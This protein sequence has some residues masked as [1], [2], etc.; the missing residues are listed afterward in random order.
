MTHV[1][2]VPE[3]VLAAAAELDLLADRLAGV[4]AT[5]GPATHVIP[6]G[7]E[8]VSILAATHFNQVATLQHQALGKG[9]LEL[10]NAANTLRT[11]VAQY[12]G[13]DLAN[14]ATIGTIPV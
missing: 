3:I 2:V 13:Q 14:A 6:S 1:L 4:A 12:L 5:T 8:E 11:H 9:I 7:T 10:R